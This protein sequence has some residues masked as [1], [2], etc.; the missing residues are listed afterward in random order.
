MKKLISI[1]LMV[2]LML[3]LCITVFAAYTLPEHTVPGSTQKCNNTYYTIVHSGHV[4]AYTMGTHVHTDGNI[5]TIT[6]VRLTHTIRCTS[7]NQVVESFD[8]TCTI[9]HSIC[10]ASSQDCSVPE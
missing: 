5:C 10:S 9:S 6:G 2:L 8:K 4:A 1:V 3:S 7:C